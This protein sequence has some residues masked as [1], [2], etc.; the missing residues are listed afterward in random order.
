M[1]EHSRKRSRRRVAETS[2]GG[3]VISSDGL[4]TIALIGRETR[5]KHLEWCVPKGHP[6]GDES[7]EA[8][9]I[10]EV[11]EETGIEAEIVSPLGSI[12]YTF[13]AGNVVI[14]KT[15]HHYIMRQLGGTLTV[16][17]DP[18]HEAVTA[19]WVSINDLSG[20][21]THENERRLALGVIEWVEHNK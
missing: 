21:L 6:E 12:E 9:A 16:E 5:A 3:F 11:F 18:D 7:L 2:A 17:N 4:Q 14:T 15:V 20:I 8:A 1:A 13:S 19:K 10:R